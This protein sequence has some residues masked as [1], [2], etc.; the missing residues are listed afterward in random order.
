MS[1][2]LYYF[3]ATATDRAGNFNSTSTYNITLDTLNPNITYVPYTDVSGINVS[4]SWL[5]VNVTANDSNIRWINISVYDRLL[6]RVWTQNYSAPSMTTANNLSL[7][8]TALADGL[9]YFNA[10]VT[11]RAGNINSTS[12]YNVTLDTLK[13]NITY[14]PFTESN[15]NNVS[16]TWFAINVTANDSNL[17]SINISV[18][19]SAL[20]LIWAQ[21]YSAPSLTT[22]NNLSVN[23]TGMLM[24]CTTSMQLQ[25]IVQETSTALQRTISRSTQ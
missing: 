13:P 18:Y 19:N 3:N 17:E 23:M 5:A 6:T 10:T 2:G 7:N 22:L 20:S 12:T 8:L 24:D 16:R 25:Q 9:Y 15:G 11:D 1:D 21:N 14:V 4:R